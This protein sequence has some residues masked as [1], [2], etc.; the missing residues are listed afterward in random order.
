MPRILNGMWYQESRRRTCD[1]LLYLEE[2]RNIR[3]DLIDD[4]N[5]IAKD[6]RSLIGM[7]GG[8]EKRWNAHDQYIAA[9]AWG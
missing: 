1:R 9:L 4:S 8:L 2:V 7:Q 3:M 5:A 6:S